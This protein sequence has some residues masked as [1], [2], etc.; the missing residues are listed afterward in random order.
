MSALKFLLPLLFAVSS[1][2]CIAGQT[3]TLEL[4]SFNELIASAREKSET[5]TF[6]P[7]AVSLLFIAS[8]SQGRPA[9]EHQEEIT[10]RSEPEAFAVAEVVIKRTGFMD[11]SISGDEYQFRLSRQP[12]NEWLIESVHHGWRCHEGRGHS[13]L[14][15]APCL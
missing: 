12:G 4:D 10:L 15:A 8:R 6:H 2:A 13:D 7:V 3:K 5:W 14:S 9:I 11:D 1:S